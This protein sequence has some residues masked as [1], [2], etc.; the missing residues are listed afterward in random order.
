MAGGVVT[1]Q[2]ITDEEV[3]ALCRKLA[4]LLEDESGRGM[5]SW[6]MAITLVGEQLYN[7]LGYKLGKS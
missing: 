3:A 1:D 5:A 2:E 6:Y 4:N 7:A